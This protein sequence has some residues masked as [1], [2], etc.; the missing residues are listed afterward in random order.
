MHSDSS[1]LKTTCLGLKCDCFKDLAKRGDAALLVAI[2]KSRSLSDCP[3]SVS[4]ATTLLFKDVH[5]PSESL[6]IGSWI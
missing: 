6:K 1:T 2:E 3:E 5:K 4:V